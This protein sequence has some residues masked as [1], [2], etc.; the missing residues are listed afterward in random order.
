MNGSLLLKNS[1]PAG[2]PGI[3]EEIVEKRLDLNELTVRN[4]EATYFVR[5]EGNS[6]EGAGIYDGDLLV[7][8]RSLQ[9]KQGDIVVACLNG[10]FTVKR[11][12]DRGGRFYLQA[13]NSNYSEIPIREGDEFSCWGK[14]TYVIHKA[15]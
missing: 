8:D 12:Q 14:V 6:M 4:P 11:L 13:E 9:G 3:V 2:F 15:I 5:V 7:V 1:I 10:K